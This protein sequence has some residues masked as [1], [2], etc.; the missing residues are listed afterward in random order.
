[1]KTLLAILLSIAPLALA[2]DQKLNCDHRSSHGWNDWSYCEM[3]EATIPARAGITVDGGANGGI[4]VHG[5]DRNQILVRS[6]TRVR[7]H[8]RAEAKDIAAHIRVEIADGRIHPEGPQESWR[9][10]GGWGVSFEIFVPRHTDLTLRTTNGG[11]DLEDVHGRMDFNTTNGGVTLK[12]VSGD[13]DGHTTNGGVHIELSG[14]HWDGEKCDVQ[15][16]NGGVRILV[17]A[18]YSAHLEAETT[19]GGVDVDFPVTVHGRIGR[20]FEADLGAGGRTIRV[21]TTNGGVAL[22]RLPAA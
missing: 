11:V 20:H 6:Q 5:W 7:V 10:D 22:K 15:T 16:T 17:P 2:Q 9:H 12:R 21:T 8:D 19:H 14:D 18:N 4:S 3:H 13:V 1:M